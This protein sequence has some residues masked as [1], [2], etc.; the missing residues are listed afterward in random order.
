MAGGESARFKSITGSEPVHKN[1]FKLPNG[2]TMIEMAIRMYKASGLTKFVALVYSEAESIVQ[3]LGDGS[4]LGVEIAYSYDPGKPVGKGGAV[5]NALEGGVLSAGQYF[6]V[7]NP[8]D[9]ILGCEKTFPRDIISGHLEGESKGT[10]ATVVVVEETPYPYTG[11]KVTK[12]IVDQ[13]EMYPMIPVPTHIGV[14]VFSPRIAPY[15]IE[16]FDYEHR[17]D[18][19]SVLFPILSKEKKLYATSI[20]NNCWLA[21]N[22]PK[23]YKELLKALN[24]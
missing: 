16:N 10:L 9:V 11:M 15:F 4:S 18:F 1:I 17:A 6:I 20:P 3:A 14:T 13:I 24:L 2:D 12:N 21:V 19:E 23:S 22:N 8:D 7:H 5:K